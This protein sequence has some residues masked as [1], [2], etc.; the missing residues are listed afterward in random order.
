MCEPWK[1]YFVNYSRGFY[2]KV[3]HQ[4]QWKGG[5]LRTAMKMYPW[6]SLQSTCLQWKRILDK[7]WTGGIILIKENLTGR[8]IEQPLSEYK[9]L[10]ESS[11]WHH[12]CSQ[13]YISILML[14]NKHSRSQKYL[15]GRPAVLIILYFPPHH[16][17]LHFNT[18]G[19]VYLALAKSDTLGSVTFPGEAATIMELL[20]F[21]SS[22]L[23]WALLSWDISW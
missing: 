21:F 6:I 12:K 16:S 9:S 15:E 14:D 13:A 22:A 8:A 1:V 3:S 18:H 17:S 5:Y 2:S 11:R 7:A 23:T 19:F 10:F 20:S 4:D